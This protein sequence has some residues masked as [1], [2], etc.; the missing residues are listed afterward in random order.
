M[1]TRLKLFDLTAGTLFIL[2]CFLTI[3]PFL[4]A[5]S[6]SLSSGQEVLTE[7]VTFW[8][9][10][11]TLENYR[12]VFAN[13]SILHA[14]MIS[15][16]KTTAGTLF[17]LVVIATAAYS[18][19]KR[20]L[21]MKKWILPFFIIPM[22]VSGGLL[23]FYILIYNL[24]LMNTFMVYILPGAFSGLFMFLMKVYYE[25]LPGEVEES[26]KID[27][28]GD[29]RIFVS[30]F[31]PLSAPVYATVALF[32]GVGQWNAWFD[33]LLFVSNDQLHPLQLLL[34]NIL[35]EA[36]I[37]TF[38]QVAALS[39]PQAVKQ[40]SVETLRMATLMVATFP[41]LFIY[42]FFQRYFI[43]GVALGAVKG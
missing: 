15:V 35:R 36:E 38:A 14:F 20:H 4:Y 6:Y 19:S 43:K 39:S 41:I 27:G 30:I 23:P 21:I 26:A 2:L 11:F 29:F 22:Y 9:V 12:T 5:L 32:V 13:N 8:P 7:K 10:G 17:S 34:Q 16:L 18:V 31:V 37:T 28:A 25:T 33:A 1:R 40:T 24:G 3:Y 42:P